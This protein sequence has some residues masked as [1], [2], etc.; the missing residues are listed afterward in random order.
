MKTMQKLF[1]IVLCMLLCLAVFG[2]NAAPAPSGDADK[3]FTV[4]ICQL[5]KHDALDDATKGFRDA[6]KEKLG[7]RVVFVEQI[8][9]GDPSTCSVICTQFV[10]DEVDL[11]LANATPALQAAQAA[12]N[13]I[14]VLGTSVTD[15]GAALDIPDF[16][17]TTGT[18]ISGTSDRVPE[19]EQV[20][21]LN[22]LFPDA[23]NVGILYCS[24][25]ANSKVQADA[26]REAAESLGCAVT[27]F[28]FA[29]SNDLAQVAAEACDAS[30]VLYIPTDNTA[31]ANAELIN[32]VALNARTPIVC[33]E[34]SLCNGC[35]VATLSISY[36]DLGH[37]TGEMAFEILENG[38]DV[39]TLEVQYAPFTRL[40]NPTLCDA[41]GI[42]VPDGFA[43][44]E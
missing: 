18:N 1:A 15:Y 17:G 20:K 33:G 24:A 40:F 5:V 9:A 27:E 10:S 12:T 16:N 19:S 21:V 14:P 42:T 35:G 28:R 29:D 23:K 32:N 13:T 6:L 31:A 22:E 25:E 2:C 26:F 39:S 30:D 8:A 38:A 44:I 7:D 37:V 4:G 11:I 3:V 41:L 43:P 34:E 36:Y